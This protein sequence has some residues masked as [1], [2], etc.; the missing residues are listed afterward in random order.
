MPTIKRSIGKQNGFLGRK[1]VKFLRD[2]FSAHLNKNNK[3]V[4]KMTSESV[5]HG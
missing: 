3:L 2:D 4:A 5:L 1:A